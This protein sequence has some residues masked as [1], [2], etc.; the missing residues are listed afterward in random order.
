MT[1]IYLQDGVNVDLGDLVSKFA[2]DI[3]KSTYDFSPIAKVV[4]TTNGNFRGPRGIQLKPDFNSDGFIW[5]CAPDGIGTKVI[6]TDSVCSHLFSAFDLI[7]MTSFDLVRGGACLFI[8]LQ[9]WM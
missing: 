9:Y 4:D 8:L 6:I 3:C 5:S 2:A 7:A 1:S